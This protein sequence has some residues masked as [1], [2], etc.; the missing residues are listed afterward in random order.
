MEFLSC[1]QYIAQWHQRTLF[2]K[3]SPAMI[4]DAGD[5]ALFTYHKIGCTEENRAAVDGR[6]RHLSTNVE[7]EAP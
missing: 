1:H 6:S 3:S 7:G 2:E 4:A 5:Y